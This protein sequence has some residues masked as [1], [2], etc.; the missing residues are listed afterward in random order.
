MAKRKVF[1]KTDLT[2][3]MVEHIRGLSGAIVI[4]LEVI[5]QKVTTVEFHR[6][7]RAKRFD[8][9]PYY[10]VGIDAIT[11][12]CQRQIERFI[13]K[14]DAELEVITVRAYCTMG[15]VHFLNYFRI[16]SAALSRELTLDDINRDMVDGFLQFLKDDGASPASQKSRY[17]RTKAVLKALCMRSLIREI[18]AGDEAT[19]PRN[20]FPGANNT[21]LGSR[22]RR[23]FVAYQLYF[24][25]SRDLGLLDFRRSG[26][27]S[28]LLECVEGT[29]VKTRN[30]DNFVERNRDLKTAREHTVRARSERVQ[31]VTVERVVFNGAVILV[32]VSAHHGL[33]TERFQRAGGVAGF[34]DGADVNL[35][36]GQGNLNGGLAGR[37]FC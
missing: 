16:R 33:Q 30:H 17:D 1:V 9:A 36:V 24:Q 28:R 8:F 19:F 3:P 35:R 32:S 31:H 34:N 22:L 12:A 5:P 13:D 26:R 6:D 25:I 18:M 7:S 21:T 11:Y 2:T 10:G 15:L 20:P 27:W 37:G 4:P 14:Q 23:R 29:Q